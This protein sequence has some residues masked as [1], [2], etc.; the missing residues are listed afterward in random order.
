MSAAAAKRF[1]REVAVVEA[2]AEE[3]ADG[4]GVALDGRPLRTP[5]RRPL[6]L[7]TRALAEAVASEWAGQQDRIDPHSMPMMRLAATALDRVVDE[8]RR[9]LAEMAAYGEND[10]LCYRVESPVELVAKQAEAWDPLLAWLRRRYDIGLRV[11]SALVH[12][13][14]ET[15]ARAAFERI[16]DAF[17]PMRISALHNVTTITGSLVLALALAAREI[18]AEQT[19]ELGEIEE[20]YQIG[21]WGEDAEAMARRGAR[22]ETLADCARF[23]DLLDS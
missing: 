23:L 1:Y 18:D 5:A 19:F 17:D 9:V 3:G 11:T 15:A 22:R 6:I 21:L 12:V 4:H 10:L 13:P 2:T 14:Q 8:R 7:P 20:S 16:V